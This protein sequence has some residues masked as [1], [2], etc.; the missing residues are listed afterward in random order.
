MLSIGTRNQST[1]K[2]SMSFVVLS[3]S[4]RALIP[5]TVRSP[6][7]AAKKVQMLCSTANERLDQ[8]MTPSEGLE[9][10]NSPSQ[11]HPSQRVR[12]T[13]NAPSNGLKTRFR[14]I[15]ATILVSAC[16]TL[17]TEISQIQFHPPKI[18]QVQHAFDHPLHID[19]HQRSNLTLLQLSQRPRRQFRRGD[20]ARMRVHRLACGLPE[21]SIQL[22]LQQPSQIAVADHAKQPSDLLDRGQAKLLAAHLV[23]HV[24]PSAL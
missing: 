19:D 4:T 17:R 10:Q 9:A 6:S 1:W 21:S 12:Q 22:A 16:S 11:T 8:A 14:H 15:I 24:G 3:A 13:R 2:L 23:D 18:V 20:G 5:T 7:M